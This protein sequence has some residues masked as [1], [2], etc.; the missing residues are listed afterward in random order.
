MKPAARALATVVPLLVLAV[1]GFMLIR[2]LS[3]GLEAPAVPD[4]APHGPQSAGSDTLL[5]VL[6]AL[7]VVIAVSRALGA[8]F[9]WLKQPPVV[10]EV[11]AGIM[12]G[13]SLLGRVAPSVSAHVLPPAVA[14]Y[15]GVIAQVGVLLYMFL[16]GLH[17][18]LKVVR[19]RG[20]TAL[21]VSNASIV[22]PFIGGAGLSLWLYPRMGQSG[23]SFT[24]FALFIGVAMSVTAFPVLARILTD[25]QMHKTRL[26]SL[27]LACAA[28][29]DV[30]AW[31]LLAFLVGVV[32]ASADRALVTIGLTAVY[33][34][35]V[36]FVLRPLA[37]RFVAWH[38]KQGKTS[39]TAIAI[40]T[41]A[42]LLSALATEAI[43]IHAIFGAFL[44]GAVV[45]HDSALA[46]D[47]QAKLE[48]VVVV[49]LLPAFF[50]FTGLRTQ[51]GLVHG[52]E[53]WL[54][55]GLVL[56]CAFVGKMGGTLVAARAT[57]QGW[58]D[59]L[60]LGALMNTR[61]LMEL[62]VLNVGLDLGVL[63]PTLF[64]IM[65]LMAVLTTVATGPLLN[66]IAQTEPELTGQ[67][68]ASR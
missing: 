8:V 40:V 49:M 24:A 66:L 31:C 13:P 43:G 7:V 53:H 5:H 16:V 35:A 21:A 1:A 59:S 25:R 58:R 57:G 64:A 9:R 42:L 26:G 52:A 51:V 20:H 62:I 41:G 39:A 45:P 44:V 61:G 68:S 55:L 12:L 2:Q 6:L 47:L 32:K 15:L 37:K 65:V 3:A 33:L 50:A 4:A 19:E 10:G 63:G 23:I 67:P 27:A 54:A 29:D 34:C 48:D 46:K 36:F 30:S 18:D 14:P 22:V 11:I 38:E 56:L 28:V 17:L 60:A